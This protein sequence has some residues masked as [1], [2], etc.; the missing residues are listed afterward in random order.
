MMSGKKVRFGLYGYGN[1]V[2]KAEGGGIA[3]CG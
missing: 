1:C 2:A 3:G